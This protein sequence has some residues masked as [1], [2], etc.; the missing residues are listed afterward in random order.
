MHA[1]IA[2][3]I[4]SFKENI[5]KSW[6]AISFFFLQ[7]A[8]LA[9]IRAAKSG[10]ANAYMQSKRN[11]L[12]SNQ[13][14]VQPHTLSY[15]I[16]WCNIDWILFNHIILLWVIKK[17]ATET[18]VSFIFSFPPCISIGC[19]RLDTVLRTIANDSWFLIMIGY[20]YTPP[21]R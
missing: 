15:L 10:S 21:I 12:L 6:Q 9:R 19:S 5:H 18:Q 8:R 11:G 16:H 20:L 7:K 14:Q 1:D 3:C 13:L 17:M 4:C 2:E